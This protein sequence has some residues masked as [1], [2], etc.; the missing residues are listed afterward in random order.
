MKYA[1]QDKKVSRHKMDHVGLV[2]LVDGLLDVFFVLQIFRNFLLKFD[3]RG[4]EDGVIDKD[5]YLGFCSMLS[6]TI[7]EDIY[8]E[9]ALRTLFDLRL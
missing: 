7:N 5:E 2:A 4:Q 8:F 1:S 9:Y 3:T 6:A